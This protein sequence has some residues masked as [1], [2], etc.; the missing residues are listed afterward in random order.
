M[1]LRGFARSVEADLIAACAILSSKRR[2]RHM[3]TR[4]ATRCR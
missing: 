2:F 4:A 3:L 1:L